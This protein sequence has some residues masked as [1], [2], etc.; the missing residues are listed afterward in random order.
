M[1]RLRLET[2]DLREQVGLFVFIKTHVD[3]SA[4]HVA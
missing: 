4:C 1:L 2:K 3:M